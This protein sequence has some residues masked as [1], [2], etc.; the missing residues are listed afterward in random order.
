MS[1]HKRPSK[2]SGHPLTEAEFAAHKMRMQFG[3]RQF[4]KPDTPLETI[5]DETLNAA[6][7]KDERS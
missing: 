5:V 1:D 7:V 3:G 6:E 4:L 2:S